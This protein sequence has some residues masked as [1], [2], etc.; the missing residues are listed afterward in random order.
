MTSLPTIN[1][2]ANTVDAVT[3]QL[4][5]EI[6]HGLIRPG[7]RIWPKQLAKRFSVSHIPI[8][9]ALR[10]LEAED[11]VSAT[12]HGASYATDV[13]VEDIDGI[14]ALRAVVEGEFAWQSAKVRSRADVN[15]VRR[16]RRQLEQLAPY[17]EEYYSIHREFHWAL[18]APAA[19]H[20]IRRVLDR[21][22]RTTDRHLAVAVAIDPA[23]PAERHATERAKE[24][25]KLVAKFASGDADGLRIAIHAHL[26]NSRTRLR[27]SYLPEVAPRDA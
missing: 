27:S 22:W 5:A 8:R 21:L 18:L 24:H 20:V 15:E 25:R 12:S 1:L 6:V 9:E 16:L 4:R 23:F 11:L 14:Y 10:R 2:R 17:D 3:A 13:H 19:S 7:E 26:T